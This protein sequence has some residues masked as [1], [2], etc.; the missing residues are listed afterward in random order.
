MK[1]VLALLI[2]LLFFNPGLS[3]AAE[4]PPLEGIIEP[5]ELV[6]FSSQVPGILEEVRVDRGTWVKRGQI[7]ATLKSGVQQ[8][9]VD[10]AKAH[11]DFGKR[12]LLRN[13]ALIKKQLISVHDKDEIE[14]QIRFAELE[15][16]EAE[17]QLALRTIKSTIDGVVVERTGAAG[18]YVGEDPFLTVAS[19]DPLSVEVVVPAA[20]YGM[21]KKGSDAQLEVTDPIPG[22]YTA[23]V[24]IVDQIID[25]AT[26]TFAVR[27]ELPN[28][29]KQLPAGLKC[30]VNFN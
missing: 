7:I 6:Q 29:Q 5:N 21:I 26:S 8:A 19:I 14:T 30:L 25:A 10:L 27:L 4:I 20:Y 28:P 11:V 1:N 9:A 22:N 16:A 15:L 13:E 18:E 23:K 24:A 12:K 17:Q 2:S 3:A